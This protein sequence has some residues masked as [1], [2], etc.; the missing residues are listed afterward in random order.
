MGA[1]IRVGSLIQNFYWIDQVFMF[2]K[3]E[4]F[5][6]YVNKWWA[7]PLRLLFLVLALLFTESLYTEISK[8]EISGRA[9]VEANVNDDPFLYYPTVISESLLNAMLYY[10]ALYA[11]RKKKDE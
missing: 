2:H 5:K 6:V 3:P 7:V 4:F 10:L 8:G 11:I 9:G 1:N